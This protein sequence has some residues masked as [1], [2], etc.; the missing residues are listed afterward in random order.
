MS[1]AG[2]K[3]RGEEVKE[4]GRGR[5]EGEGVNGEVGGWVEGVRT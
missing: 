3:R 5:D 4:E 2:S 1:L